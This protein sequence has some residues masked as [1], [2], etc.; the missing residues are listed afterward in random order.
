MTIAVAQQ[1]RLF[2]ERAATQCVQ[3]AQPLNTL[4]DLRQACPAL[5]SGAIHTVRPDKYFVLYRKTDEQLRAAAPAANQV[6]L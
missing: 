4:E 5:D 3:C 6:S 2:G 1:L